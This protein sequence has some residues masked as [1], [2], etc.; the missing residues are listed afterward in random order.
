MVDDFLINTMYYIN[1][2][3]DFVN[4]ASIHG[5]RRNLQFGLFPMSGSSSAGVAM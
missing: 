5:S 1:L 3:M 2:S 4:V